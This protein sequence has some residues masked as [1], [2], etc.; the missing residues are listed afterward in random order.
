V[1][2]RFRMHPQSSKSLHV[3]DRPLAIDAHDG[4]ARSVRF[5][6]AHHLVS[7]GADGRVVLW[8][9]KSVDND[10]ELA[11]DESRSVGFALSPDGNSLLYCSNREAVIADLR[12][13]TIC[14]RRPAEFGS[15]FPAWSPS[16]SHVAMRTSHSSEFVIISRDGSEVRTVAHEGL[17]E[18][19]DYSP[20]GDL[21]AC[22]GDKCLQAYDPQ[23]GELLFSY[24]LPA[25][26]TALA[27]SPDGQ[28]LVYALV[29]G[30]LGVLAVPTRQLLQELTTPSDVIAFQHSPVGS[31]LATGHEDSVIRIWDL[32]TGRLQLALSGHER[33]INDLVYSPDGGTLISS[34][35]DQSVRVWSLKHGQCFGIIQQGK[36]GESRVSLSADGRK[37][38]T[39]IRRHLGP[40]T[41]LLQSL[42]IP[43]R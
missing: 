10:L 20:A 21:L 31:I 19:M 34:S 5:V 32:S 40:P 15:L 26:G 2:E 35:I 6:D 38:A 16:S 37:L 28:I 22:I 14:M 3:E 13:Q 24:P 17:P 18:A 33:P 36:L 4:Q 27:F 7:C 23:S 30:R 11:P 39:C 25:K 12:S 1:I 43:G 41:V 29:G 8:N 9:L 42:S